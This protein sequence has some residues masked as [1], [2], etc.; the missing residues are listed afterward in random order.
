MQPNPPAAQVVIDTFDPSIDFAG[1]PM[2]ATPEIL[3]LKSGTSTPPGTVVAM[4]A[5]EP[6]GYGVEPTAPILSCTHNLRFMPVDADNCTLRTYAP[7]QFTWNNITAWTRAQ[8]AGAFRDKARNPAAISNGADLIKTYSIAP[9]DCTPVSE[10]NVAAAITSNTQLSVTV[11]MPGQ[12]TLNVCL[13]YGCVVAVTAGGAA[14]PVTVVAASSASDAP[15]VLTVARQAGGSYPY[16]TAIVVTVTVGSYLPA[17]HFASTTTWCTTRGGA[18][19]T[20]PMPHDAS[21]VGAVGSLSPRPAPH[22]LLCKECL[23]LLMGI[24]VARH[25]P[26]LLPSQCALQ[27]VCCSGCRELPRCLLQS[28]FCFLRIIFITLQH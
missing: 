2:A 26:G 6:V 7:N 17:A 8:L 10:A 12:P 28:T 14:M 3:S 18:A 4:T 5:S 19:V 25:A 22:G 13:Q 23:C 24:H 21:P 11:E 15:S 20:A 16:N 9:Y 1:L 27:P